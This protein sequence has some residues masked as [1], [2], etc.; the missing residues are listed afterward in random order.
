M[1]STDGRSDLR[2][3]ERTDVP[4][5]LR[6][7]ARTDMSLKIIDIDSRDL[8]TP[9]NVKNVMTD[10]NY[11]LWEVNKN[12][13]RLSTPFQLSYIVETLPSCC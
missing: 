6:T 1:L 2:T 5:T 8:K 10:Y 7:H 13:S 11:S 9:R 4:T 3:Y 12:K